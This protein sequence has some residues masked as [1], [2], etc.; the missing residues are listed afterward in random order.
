VNPD[1]SVFL[2]AY[3]EEDNIMEAVASSLSVLKEISRQFEVIV[4]VYEGSTDNTRKIVE[5]LTSKDGRIRLVIQRKDDA[6]YGAAMRLGY[7]NSRYPLIF[8]TDADNQF[9]ITELKQLLPYLAEADLVVGYR[10]NRMDPIGRLLA[11][12]IYNLLVRI[13]FGLKVRDVDCAF[14]LVRKEIF[15]NVKLNHDTGISD[16]ELLVKAKRFGY[17]I[18]EVPVSHKPRKA[19]SAVF[20]EGGFGFVKPSVVFNLLKDMIKLKVELSSK[21]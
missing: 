9:D 5:E 3:N 21:R 15:D 17:R 6:G 19:G 12:R 18:I 14:K 11:A 2:L 7:E 1:I 16:A 10:V 13:I 4:V 20:H 8:Y